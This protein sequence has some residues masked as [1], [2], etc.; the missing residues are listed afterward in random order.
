MLLEQLLRWD[1]ELE[2]GVLM[3]MEPS[4]RWVGVQRWGE[5]LWFGVLMLK[6]LL[7]ERRAGGWLWGWW[8]GSGA[9]MLE[10]GPPLVLVGALQHLGV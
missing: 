8:L 5:R 1:G 9:L 10:M 3:L 6:E 2:F 7:L 4:W